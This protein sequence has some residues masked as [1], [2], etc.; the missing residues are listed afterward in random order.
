MEPSWAYWAALTKKVPHPGPLDPHGI[1]LVFVHRHPR[2]TPAVYHPVAIMQYAL[3]NYNLRLAGDNEAG[4]AFSRCARWV[5]DNAVE[6]PKGRFAV[7]QYHFPTWTPRLRPPWISGM[8]QGQGLSVLTRAFL[9]TDSRRTAEVAHKAAQS[10]AYTVAEGGVISR[11]ADG[12]VFVEEV[13]AFPTLHILN[14]CLTGLIG[15]FEYLRVFPNAQLQT[16]F[17]TALTTVEN[18]LSAFD[19]GFWSRYS[20]GVRWDVASVRYHHVH[21]SQL[22]YFA[23]TFERRAFAERA[24]RWERYARSMMY[25]CLHRV[26]E[27]GFLNAN[28]VM[29]GLSLNALKYRSFLAPPRGVGIY[30][31]IG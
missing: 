9:D 11:P 19:L 13:A 29:T 5:E 15:L 7:W 30:P 25:R 26:V 18:W 23:K 1:P 8:A 10:F 14:G 2:G 28:R 27:F 16:I 4:R 24:E 17:D 6:D 22:R 12:A 3:R 31:S 20:L 21:I